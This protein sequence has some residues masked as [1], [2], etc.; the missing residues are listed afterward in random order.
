MQKLSQSLGGTSTDAFWC[1]TSYLLTSAVVQP[2]VIAL[3]DVLSSRLILIVAVLFFTLG[4]ILC[5]SAQK[6]P[7]LLAGRSI[8]GVG[9]GALM[10]MPF[11][12]ATEIIPLRQRPKY[13]AIVLVAGAAGAI[14]GPMVGGLLTDNASWRWVFYINFPFCALGLLMIAFA[15]L[16]SGNRPDIKT[17]LLGINWFGGAL[18]VASACSAL[19]GVTWG[20]VQFPWD[21]WHT[22]IPIALGVAGLIGALIWEVFGASKPFFPVQLFNHRPAIAGYICIFLQG[23][24]VSSSTAAE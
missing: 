1:G 3:S 24:L 20:G 14:C 16:P 12:V 18:F 9:G 2:F 11:I 8:Q 23:L 10:S 7:Q 19:I 4:T 5:C 13:T 6:F 21:S 15:L 17:G 22:Y